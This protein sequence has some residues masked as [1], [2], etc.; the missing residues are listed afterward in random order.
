MIPRYCHVLGTVFPPAEVLNDTPHVAVSLGTYV[1]S[2]DNN[3][4]SVDHEMWGLIAYSSWLAR[5]AAG[6]NNLS[7]KIMYTFANDSPRRVAPGKGFMGDG[8]NNKYVA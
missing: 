3:A 6:G 2:F 1:L 5:S 7:R 8:I 4:S